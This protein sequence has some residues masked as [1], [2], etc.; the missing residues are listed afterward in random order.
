MNTPIL[1][2][3]G[4]VELIV[5][6][7]EDITEYMK[8]ERR[9]HEMEQELFLRAR[10][11][12]E[13]ND[14]LSRANADLEERDREREAVL[15]R[16]KELDELKSAFFA[17]VSHEFRTPVALVLGALE[18]WRDRGNASAEQI[19]GAIRGAR[20][21][22]KLVNN[23]LDFS[24]IEAGR[25]DV[26]FAPTDLARMTQDLASAFQSLVVDAGLSYELRCDAL[27]EPVYVD[28]DA[29]EKIVLNLISNAFKHTLEG[30]IEVRLEERDRLARLSVA[31]TGGG[32]AKEDQP[33][34]FER[35][36]RAAPATAR[37]IE[38]SGIG[39][40]LVRE[41]VHMHGGTIDLESEP[42]SGAR[43]V[44]ELPL[45]T[46]HLPSDQVDASPAG[47]WTPRTTEAFVGEAVGWGHSTATAKARSD[48]GPRGEGDR[49]AILVAEDNADMRRFIT[50][51][52]SPYFAV[53]EATG[54]EAALSSA[55]EA[56]PEVVVADIMMPGIDG[57]E[58]LRE[59]RADEATRT[60]PVM[61]VSARA[62]EEAR[63][64]G[65]RAGADDYLV[66]PFSAG[67]LVERVQSLA[68]RARR[69]AHAKAE[70]RRKDE[71]LA[72]L[73]HELRNPLAPLQTSVE[74]LSTDSSITASPRAARA[75]AM[76]RRQM[77][78]LT[79]ILDELL[80]VSRISRG[81]IELK[82]ERIDLRE[83]A[84][85][86]AEVTR[87]L[88]D[89]QRH[90][91]SIALSPEPAYVQADRVR[92]EQVVTNLLR[93]AAKFTREGGRIELVVE[94]TGA[95]AILRVRDNGLGL[96]PEELNRVFELFSRGKRRLEGPD[97]GLGVGLTIAD[98]LVA[99]HGGRVEARS[100]GRDRGTEM[101]V[102]L[103]AAA[104]A[105][106]SP[107][108]QASELDGQGSVPG[109]GRGPLRVLIID[110]ERDGADLLAELCESWGHEGR[111]VYDPEAALAEVERWRPDAVFVDIGL[112]GMSGHELCERI[113]E[114]PGKAPT[115]VALTGYGQPADREASERVGFDDHLVKP[116]SASDIASVLSA[117]GAR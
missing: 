6:R 85:N 14:R 49:A 41:L 64:E 28:R 86:A 70:S 42:H 88:I 114:A 52:L 81:H 34:I 61:L 68:E 93:N 37:T 17:N 25:M 82:P 44:V 26:S 103:P 98:R 102:T 109:G 36:Y 92:M 65:L 66:K 10:E 75:V 78:T 97:A 67:E 1:G 69:E 72:M 54:G 112:P 35:F 51:L 113:R 45:G 96:E 33:H 80:E 12:E 104:P 32:I 91:L 40:A 3:R 76:M 99:L 90:S 115:M 77:K 71:F 22:L 87:R 38:G 8:L 101:R 116:A 79:R 47:E 60:I 58:L 83:I 24:R 57:L 62:G 105:E 110:D 39:L 100:E 31:D 95:H 27:S 43:F 89:E 74:R 108:P 29:Y 106:A 4:E 5:H 2:E 19:D 13:V 20:R 46:A 63:V 15:R 111:A 107:A 21:L 11:V 50:S 30:R 48:G 16:L 84:R 7:V 53:R 18:Q 55:K 9:G 59:L 117:A 56:P 23:M 73:G 94:S